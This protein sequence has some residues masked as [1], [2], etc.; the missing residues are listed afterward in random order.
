[1]ISTDGI[2]KPGYAPVMVERS[3]LRGQ[4]P[5][6]AAL[7][8]GTKCRRKWSGHEGIDLG[9]NGVSKTTIVSGS[10]E[11]TPHPIIPP[12][13]LDDLVDELRRG[14]MKQGRQVAATDLR[15]LLEVCPS[16]SNQDQLKVQ[17]PVHALRP[18]E[19]LRP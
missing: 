4:F 7:P 3:F 16:Q 12:P 6:G 18:L 2:Y 1:M 9:A 10:G 14:D 19:L 13:K 11:R 8:P 5:T 15:L 17:F